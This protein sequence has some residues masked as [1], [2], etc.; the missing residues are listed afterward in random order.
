MAKVPNDEM[1]LKS[2]AALNHC[3]LI[4]FSLILLRSIQNTT[5]NNHDTRMDDVENKDE[6][7]L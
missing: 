7:M 4:I 5:A 1:I 3:L 6:K 2:N